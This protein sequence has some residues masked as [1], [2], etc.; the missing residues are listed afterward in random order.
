MRHLVNVGKTKPNKPKVKIGKMNVTPFIT[1][2][3][4]QRTMNDEKNKPNLSTRLKTEQTQFPQRDTQYAIRDTNNKPNPVPKIKGGASLLR[5]APFG[6]RNKRVSTLF[7]LGL[8]FLKQ[9]SEVLIF[10]ACRFQ[11]EKLIFD[12]YPQVV[13]RFLQAIDAFFKPLMAVLSLFGE[14]RQLFLL[15][16]DHSPKFLYQFIKFVFQSC[17]VHRT[18]LF[19]PPF[20]FLRITLILERLRSLRVVSEAKFIPECLKKTSCPISLTTP[21]KQPI[22]PTLCVGLMF[23]FY[24]PKRNPYMD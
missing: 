3:Y 19:S 7:C 17:F 18:T 8:F 20:S 13:Q 9:I 10:S 6:D 15:W 12:T 2:N 21:V 23:C 24:F 1:M 16:I 22:R 5:A 11:V 14:H 4:E